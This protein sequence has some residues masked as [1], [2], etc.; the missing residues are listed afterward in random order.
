MAAHEDIA[1]EVDQT[2][3]VTSDFG[4]DSASDTVE[5]T[6][7]ASPDDHDLA[8]DS[9]VHLTVDSAVHPAVDS[10]HSDV[11]HAVDA[12]V[13][14]TEPAANTTEI[15][16]GATKRSINPDD[17]PSSVP[18]AKRQKFAAP[19]E[20]KTK[21]AKTEEKRKRREAIER[22]VDLE[23]TMWEAANP[24]TS[25]TS[26]ELRRK[27][28]KKDVSDRFMAR[29]HHP[30]QIDVSSA[31]PKAGAPTPEVAPAV[32]RRVVQ[33]VPPTPQS[34]AAFQVGNAPSVSQKPKAKDASAKAP[35]G[36]KSNAIQKPI[37]STS[38]SAKNDSN[39]KLTVKKPEH[40][41]S[42]EEA[43]LDASNKAV[44]DTLTARAKEAAVKTINKAMEEVEKMK[45]DADLEA[46]QIIDKARARAEEAVSKARKEA[47]EVEKGIMANAQDEVAKIKKES[48]LSREKVLKDAHADNAIAE[49]DMEEVRRKARVRVDEARKAL[50]DV[51]KATAMLREGKEI[52]EAYLLGVAVDHA[53]GELHE[54]F[55]QP[56]QQMELTEPME[57][58]EHELPEK[59]EVLEKHEL[60]D[61]YVVK[62]E[63]DCDMT[64]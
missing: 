56:D 35:S 50:H 44:C 20:L 63:L 5:S 38:K 60:P 58:V 16:T 11:G 23:A 17:D 1:A 13:G 12:I 53:P 37:S 34:A 24:D 2:M 6:P 57:E 9:V 43:I 8:L 59:N 49:K 26:K 61:D 64:A 52:F 46:S 47:D 25:K 45:E 19:S 29:G 28:I 15:G 55:A 41:P 39:R 36:S 30:N 18:V 62:Q 32:A 33:S 54:K 40:A 31:K 21:K 4:E 48:Q 7:V 42:N 3:N 22:E 27:A 51:D 10:T 14:P